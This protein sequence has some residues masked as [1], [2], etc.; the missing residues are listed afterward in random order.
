MD[1]HFGELE[2]QNFFGIRENAS[3]EEANASQP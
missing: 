1:F 3:G 2:I